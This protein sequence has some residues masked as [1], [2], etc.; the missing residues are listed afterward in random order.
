MPILAPPTAAPPNSIDANSS[1]LQSNYQDNQIYEIDI[2]QI[3]ADYIKNIDNKRSHINIIG[4]NTKQLLAAIGGNPEAPTT[5]NLVPA[6]SLQESRCH[7]FF[8]IIGFPVVNSNQSKYYNPGHDIIYGQRSLTLAAKTAIAEDPIANFD[9]L[10]NFREQYPL[11]SMKIFAT[12]NTVDAGVLSLSGG[13][14]P[15]G[16]R[17]FSSPFLINQQPFDVVTTNQV[18]SGVYVSIVGGG[19]PGDSSEGNINLTQYYDASYNTPA[20]ATLTPDKYH[21]IKP[22]IVDPRIDF[23]CSPSTNRI[24]VPFVPNNSFLQISSTVYAEPPFLEIVIRDRFTVTNQLQNSG[25]ITQQFATVIKEASTAPPD[26]S[27][28]GQISQNNIQQLS[29]NSQFVQ[30]VNIIQA[31]VKK[32]VEAQKNIGSAQSQYYWLP[33]PSTSG[34]EGGSSVQGVFLPPTMAIQNA[35]NIT[36]LITSYDGDILI[37]TA[38][39]LF[40]QTQQNAQATSAIGQ[41]DPGGFAVSVKNSLGPSS[42]SSYVNNSMLNLDSLTSRRQGILSKANDSLR[43][44]EI[45][46]GEFSGLGL[47][48]MIAVLG[49]LYTMPPLDLL[50]FLDIDA[51]ARFN[52][53][54]NNPGY[55]NSDIKTA[56]A[57]FCSTVNQFYQL[58]EALYHSTLSNQ[59]SS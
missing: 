52:I 10:S 22:F 38:Q 21:I 56:M 43:T 57:S 45:I 13:A 14:N 16:M 59:G 25:D 51:F 5:N 9:M 50:G 18:Y 32:L 3:Y 41:P 44:I 23:T 39:S 47:C 12:P 58:T 55:P 29:T 30:F 19:S 53:Q 2:D 49:A 17:P 31:M 4:Q 54:F 35:N 42:T 37:K 27:L 15:G 26:Q 8:R 36:P 28:L 6:K 34:P 1:P 7:A 40:S 11:K 48:D 46:M 20:P 33:V 24:G